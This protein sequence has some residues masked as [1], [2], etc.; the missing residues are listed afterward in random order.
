MRGIRW[1]SSFFSIIS[2]IAEPTYTQK[3]LKHFFEAGLDILYYH[4]LSHCNVRLCL[5]L[6]QI[7]KYINHSCDEGTMKQ[8]YVSLH[9]QNHLDVLATNGTFFDDWQLLCGS[10][11]VASMGQMGSLSPVAVE[12]MSRS[13]STITSGTLQQR[14]L[15]NRFIDFKPREGRLW[16]LSLISSLT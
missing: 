9:Y 2:Q 1:F 3:L 16:S 10:W 8:T 4:I 13:Q 12:P 5:G 6:R 7:I 11:L 14:N 15:I